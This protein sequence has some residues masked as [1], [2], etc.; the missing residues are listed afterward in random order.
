[1]DCT[2]PDFWEQRY[3]ENRTPWDQHGVPP[4]LINYLRQTRTPGTVLIPGCGSG[5]EVMAFHDFRWQ[6]LA[7]D[8]APAAVQQ[9]RT[10]LEAL[11]PLVRQADFFS[12]DLGGPYDL[13]YERTFLCSLPPDRWPAYAGRMAQLLRPGGRLAGIFYHGIDPDGP[14]FPLSAAQPD[15]LFPSFELV[16]DRPIPAG[17]SL[18]LFAGFERWQE[19]RL[20]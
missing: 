11:A 14:P 9:A 16:A 17:E 10:L 4:A 20:K 5:Y 19:W 13:I 6:P 18:P 8:F 3:R 15:Q 1:M 7:I 2:E 12:D